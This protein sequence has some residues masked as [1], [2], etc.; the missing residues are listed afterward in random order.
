MCLYKERGLPTYS[1]TE[2][3][4]LA[5]IGFPSPSRVFPSE[6]LTVDQVGAGLKRMG[7]ETFIRDLSM[8]PPETLK[9]WL[10]I[11]IESQIATILAVEDEGEGH[12][13]VLV[14]HGLGTPNLDTPTYKFATGENIYGS[15]CWASELLVHDDQ[16]GPYLRATIVPLKRKEPKAALKYFPS[17]LSRR[18]K[19]KV[20]NI[21]AAIVLLPPHVNCDG[22]RAEAKAIRLLHW[23]RRH[24][25]TKLDKGN[26]NLVVRTFLLSSNEFKEKADTTRS[27]SEHLIFRYKLLHLPKYVWITEWTT[28]EL[29]NRPTAEKRILGE[30]LVDPTSNPYNLDFLSLHTPNMLFFMNP[31][32]REASSA[33]RRPLEIPNDRQYTPLVRPAS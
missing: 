6:G 2:I 32:E 1:T 8:T 7:H 33:L 5:D 18:K 29:W 24:N 28:L 13:V 16:M 21:L 22:L 19:G 30:V 26:T 14:G 9:R 31:D 23:L 4:K 11:H 20:L 17:D 12:A 10:Y 3:T 27:M 15:H 25:L